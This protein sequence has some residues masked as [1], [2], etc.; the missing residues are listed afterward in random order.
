VI[1]HAPSIERRAAV[2]ATERL[3]GAAVKVRLNL[4]LLQ[5]VPAR[6]AHEPRHAR[7]V[8]RPGRARASRAARVGVVAR[9]EAARASRPRPATDATAELDARRRARDDAG[10]TTR[11]TRDRT[12]DARATA[13][14]RARDASSASEAR[15]ATRA[16]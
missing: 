1:L 7:D 10:A 2:D 9:R 4:R 5:R 8:E 12:S 3:G 14:G 15:E 13:R 11:A 16:R 6:L